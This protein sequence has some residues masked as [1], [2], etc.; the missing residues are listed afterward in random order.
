[1]DRSLFL[2]VWLG[3]EFGVLCVSLVNNP[4]G[5]V[6]PFSLKIE[7]HVVFDGG[8]PCYLLCS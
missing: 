5:A 7:W 8:S 4:T 1:M 6:S 3:L 2:L